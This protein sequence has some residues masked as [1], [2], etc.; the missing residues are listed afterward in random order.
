M[1]KYG[2]QLLDLRSKTKLRI[3]NGRTSRDLPQRLTYVGF[4]GFSTVDLV[5]TSKASLTKSTIVQYLSV[6]DL[7]F[8][9]DH[10]PILLKLTRNYNFLPN[11]IIKDTQVCELKHK[12]TR[13]TWKNS[14]GKDFALRLS[15][16]TNKISNVPL[17]NESDTNFRSEIEHTL[18]E[19]QNAFIRSA[20]GVLRRKTLKTGKKLIK[21]LLYKKWF[22]LNWKQLRTNL[23]WFGQKLNKTS[24]DPYLR[25]QFFKLKRK[26][27]STCR[28]EKRKF[29]QNITKTWN[30][31][32]FK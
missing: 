30:L 10:W 3:L 2:Q 29:E 26:Y 24:K 15:L 18:G 13:Y 23:Q 8:L 4:H 5:L 25:E 27:R 28:K 22:N 16:E 1:N 17:G 32:I 12:P 11:K 9:S 14:R 7:N 21:N 31:T 19:I 6:Q 20:E